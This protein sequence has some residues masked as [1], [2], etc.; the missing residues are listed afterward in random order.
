VRRALSPTALAMAGRPGA[1]HAS[2]DPAAWVPAKREY[3][4]LRLLLC[5]AAIEE[6]LSQPQPANRLRSLEARLCAGP[7]VHP[8]Q[9]RRGEVQQQAAARRR[10]A[11]GVISDGD[12]DSDASYISEGDPPEP[13]EP[14][15]WA[16]SQRGSW[17]RV[18]TTLKE[19][20]VVRNGVSLF[21]A[22]LRRAVPGEMLQQKGG[23]RVLTS[24]RAQGCVRMPIQPYGW[25]TADATRA[26]GPQ[27]LIRAQAPKWRAVYQSP[28]GNGAADV[29]VR[30]GLELD[31]E[32]VVSLCCGDI[33][34]QAG[35]S[36][37]R[38]NGIVRMPVV[39][40][41][42]SESNEEEDS[43]RPARI[44][45]WVTVDASAAGGPVFFKP[46]PD[47]SAGEAPPANRGGGSGRGR[48]G[49]QQHQQSS[50]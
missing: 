23:P 9:Q 1:T 20:L 13:N 27:Y 36:H 26:G 50:A 39:L 41:R 25:V 33:V 29:I 28:T 5:R 7:A 17:W 8:Q 12:D 46:L 18:R 35:P 2:F 49:R 22:E 34:E 38:S 44:S 37:I 31:S 48:R 11:A 6:E 14:I 45:G 4:I 42:K 40:G 30:H 19:D 16:K 47:N 43:P 24:G 10:P 15:A 3:G 32:A 21:S